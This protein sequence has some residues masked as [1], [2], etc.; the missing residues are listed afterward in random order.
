[1]KLL[2]NCGKIVEAGQTCFHSIMA[3]G[4]L[5]LDLMPE[6]VCILCGS[7]MTYKKL[8]WQ[9]IKCRCVT[10]IHQRKFMFLAH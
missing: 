4:R 9:L 1:M 6:T 5:P 10:V 8:N 3:D 2:C 7:F